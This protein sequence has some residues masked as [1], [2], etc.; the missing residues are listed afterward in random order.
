MFLLYLCETYGKLPG[1]DWLNDLDPLTKLYLY[2]GWLNKQKE[3]HEYDRMLS[4]FAG[5]F[6]NPE[7]AQKLIKDESPDF[8]STDKDFEKSLEI[9]ANT[10]E[11]EDKPLHRRKRKKIA[12]VKE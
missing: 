5:S 2:E 10:I 1:D 11:V 7:M 9:V 8:S 3:K 6:T 12:V 4:I